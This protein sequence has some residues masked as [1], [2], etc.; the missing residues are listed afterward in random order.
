MKRKLTPEEWERIRRPKTDAQPIYLPQPPTVFLNK[1]LPPVDEARVPAPTSTATTTNQKTKT[2]TCERTG[3]SS[4]DPSVALGAEYVVGID[5]A[6][7]G[8]ILGP[9]FVGLVVWKTSELGR[10][11]QLGVK[12]S[13]KLTDKRRRDLNA[14]IR[15]EARH[16]AVVSFSA[17]EMYNL[18]KKDSLTINSMD[19][20]LFAKALETLPEE[21]WDAANPKISLFLDAADVEEERFGLSVTLRLDEARRKSFRAVISKNHADADYPVVSAAS[22]LAKE[23]RETWVADAHALYGDFKSGYCNPPVLRWLEDYRRKKEKFPDICRT[24]WAPCAK[25]EEKLR[26]ERE[27]SSK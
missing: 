3:A 13:K 10:L 21:L 24:S 25:I 12:D 22:I 14:K 26:A 5:E 7:K 18:K 11:A 16:T 6:G 2:Q 20:M 15:A 23:A 8:C 1:T 4:S 9:M 27:N 19:E 17:H